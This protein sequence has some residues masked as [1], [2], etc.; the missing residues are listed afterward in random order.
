[1]TQYYLDSSVG[2]RILLGHSPAAA[3][4]FDDIT[5][6]THDRVVSSRL[7]RTEMTRALRRLGEPLRRRDAV[8][9]HVATVPLGA[10]DMASTWPS[11]RH[12]AAIE[13][14]VLGSR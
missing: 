9:D 1:M 14:P 10:G 3:G 12:A 8:I 11:F 7:L 4:W 13:S 6:S 2:V 5:A